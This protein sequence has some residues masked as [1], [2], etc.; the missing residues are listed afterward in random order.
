[1]SRVFIIERPRHSIDISRAE[2][3]GEIE[4]VFGDND[5]RS[6]I[7]RCTN[8]GDEVIEKMRQMHF[9]HRHD[10][11]CMV[12]SMVPISVALAAIVTQYPTVNVLFYHAAESRYV[13]KTIG[14]ALWKGQS[15]EE[16][17]EATTRHQAA[18]DSSQ[19][20]DGNAQGAVRRDA[21]LA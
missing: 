5:R 3:H 18:H 12:G 7:F 13:R 10:M 15:H 19:R 16:E 9:D 2:E 17:S 20:I 8:F 1:M 11:L 6:S 4:F 14:Q 21:D